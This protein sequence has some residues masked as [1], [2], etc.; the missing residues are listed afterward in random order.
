MANCRFENVSKALDVDISLFTETNSEKQ[1]EID[2]EKERIWFALIHLSGLFLLFF[3]TIIIWY[4]KKDYIKEITNHYRDVVNFQIN[5]WLFY[6]LSGLISFL[7]MGFPH[8]IYVGIV[9][10]GVITIVNCNKLNN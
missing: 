10:N 6:M 1:N 3:P 2:K 7:F 8:L 4:K 5:K 9:F